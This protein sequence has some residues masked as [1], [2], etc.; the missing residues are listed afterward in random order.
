MG[1]KDEKEWMGGRKN[2]WGKRMRRKGWEDG[3]MNR[4]KR[5]RRKG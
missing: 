5:M 4:E 3:R 1:K 2:E